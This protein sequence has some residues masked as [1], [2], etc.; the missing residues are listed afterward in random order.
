MYS[1]LL[2]KRLL[3]VTIALACIV[4]VSAGLGGVFRGA[5]LLGGGTMDMD[6]HFRYLSGLLLGIGLGF[7]SSIP[8]IE[9]QST[10]IRLLTLIVVIGGIARLMGFSWLVHLALSC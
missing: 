1:S 10:R 8:N 5:P 6:S 2:E 3:Q 7:F 4:P 9:R